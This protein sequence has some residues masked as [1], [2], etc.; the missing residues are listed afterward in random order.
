MLLLAF[1]LFC[2]YSF[3]FF[4]NRKLQY[5]LI[6]CMLSLLSFYCKISTGIVVFIL[7]WIL[8]LEY[9]IWGSN[10][11]YA[12]GISLIYS[13]FFLLISIIFNVDLY[14]YTKGGLEFAASILMLCT[15]GLEKT[16]LN[17]LQLLQ[18]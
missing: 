18:Y 15:K 10:R 1:I 14:G 9:F 3:L 8:F 4:E 7:Q 12:L 13:A 17:Y 16:I 11:K 2:F 5:L 6:V